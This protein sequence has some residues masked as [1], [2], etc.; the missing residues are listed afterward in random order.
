L[1]PEEWK[2]I[3]EKLKLTYN[4]VKLKVDDYVISIALRR[5]T[6][7][8]N[9]LVVYVNGQIKGEW[10]NKE[11]EE[12]RRFYRKVTHSVYSKKKKEVYMK[13]SKKLRNDLSIDIDKK[14][15]YY[16]P[17]WT[18]FKSLKKQLIEQNN[19]IELICEE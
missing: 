8:K 4:T 5:I 19:S 10:C 11:C 1:T 13:L 6:Q 18:S 16:L 12:S 3:E 2:Q 7:F 15:S 14:F 9:A 17:D